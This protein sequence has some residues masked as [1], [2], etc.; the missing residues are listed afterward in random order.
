MPT[1]EREIPYTLSAYSGGLVEQ[2]VLLHQS[3]A[4]SSKDSGVYDFKEDDDNDNDTAENEPSANKKV[5]AADVVKTDKTSLLVAAALSAAEQDLLNPTS[6]K[7]QEAAEPDSKVLVS[8]LDDDQPQVERCPTPRVYIQQQQQ[9]QQ[10]NIVTNSGF[11]ESNF[12]LSKAVAESKTSPS[13]VTESNTTESVEGTPIFVEENPQSTA[14]VAVVNNA[15]HLNHH[16][17]ISECNLPPFSTYS[18]AL[19]QLRYSSSFNVRHPHHYQDSQDFLRYNLSAEFAGSAAAAAEYSHRGSV[20]S[21]LD[22]SNST[23]ITSSDSLHQHLNQSLPLVKPPFGTGSQQTMMLNEH[24][25]TP[26]AANH[27]VPEFNRSDNFPFHASRNY[28]GSLEHQTGQAYG[29]YHQRLTRP[30][31]PSYHHPTGHHPARLPHHY[32]SSH[33]YGGYF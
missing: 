7:G 16:Q 1:I 24:L 4:I 30:P 5:S 12:N 25:L 28:S 9:Q 26:A 6:P 14:A 2:K 13:T 27:H 32:P 33:H 10:T 22:L 17:R 23:S 29:L 20:P 11:P 15:Q 3:T 18:N 31:V 19:D 8:P 21:S